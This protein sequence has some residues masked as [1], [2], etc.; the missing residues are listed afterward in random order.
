MALTKNKKTEV[1][2]DVAKLLQDSKL[3][4]FAKYQGTSVK[5]MQGLRRTASDNGTKVKVV[6]NRLFLKALESDARFKDVDKTSLTGQLLYAFNAED[7]VA[8]AQSLADFAKTETQVEFVGALMADGSLLSAEEVK[9]LSKLPGKDQ[10]IAEA[11][12]MLLSPVN[13]I[14]SALSGDMH[15]LLDGLAAKAA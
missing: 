15:G 4:V 7:E 12:A 2:D 1:V 8:P 9:T 14:T 5:S 13:D 11:V 6:K 10:L 3:T